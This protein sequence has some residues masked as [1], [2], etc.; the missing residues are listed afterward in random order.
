M[1]DGQYHPIEPLPEIFDRLATVKDARETKNDWKR[2]LGMFDSA[3]IN[4]GS[5]HY[6]GQINNFGPNGQN[7]EVAHGIECNGYGAFIMCMACN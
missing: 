3:G 5:V 4:G 1:S 7:P 2:H 6:R